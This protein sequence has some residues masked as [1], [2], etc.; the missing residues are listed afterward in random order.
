MT[1]WLG[2]DRLFGFMP[3]FVRSTTA[4]SSLRHTFPGLGKEFMPDLDE[5]SY[6]YMPTTM[7]HASIGEVLDILQ[8]Q[9][10][11]FAAIPE[12]ESVVGKL[13]RVDSPL[14]P[15]PI[16]MIETVINYKPEYVVDQNGHRLKFKYDRE[17][18]EF[19]KDENGELIPDDR[20]RPY[21]NWRDHIRNP[22]DI[23]DE[24]VKA[25]KLPGTTSAPR[26]QPIA[27][28]IVML[29]SGMRAPMGVKVKGPD[30]ETI[31]MVGMEIE[32]FL[33]EV[34]SI[35][36]A[37]VV[38]DRIVGKPYLEIDIDREAIARYGLS[39]Q[40]VQDV[41]E[42]A[43]GGKPLT[44]TVEG[45][46]RY[47]VR[48]RYQR[49]LRN[50]IEGLEGILVGSPGGVQIPL[51]ELSEIKFVRGPMVI[52][53]EDTFLVGYVIFDKKP[54]NAEVDVVR[55]AQ[56]YIQSK[57]EAGE[58]DIPAGVSYTFAGSY[59]NQVRSEKKLL[60]VLPL[61][62]VVIFLILYFQ[63]KHV[64]T[65]LL[66]FSGI[67]IAWSGGFLMIWLYGQDWFLDGSLFGIE[68]RS[69][70]QLRNYNLSVAVWV[71]FLA[72]FGIATDDGVIISTYLK[73]SFQRRKPTTIEGIREA[74]VEAG[75]RRIRPAMM[76]A[77][78]TLLA[79]I[80]V[81]TST[82]RGSDIMVPMAI[83]SFGGMFVVVIRVLTVPVLYSWMKERRLDPPGT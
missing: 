20:G 11:A 67:F 7:P 71:G 6:L 48:V 74:T 47:P 30:L 27:A 80:P 59:E 33:K 66:V 64:P 45:R 22:K 53:S 12:I 70:F 72:L 3:G 4:Y 58:F 17:F 46:E 41:I 5:G 39:I 37:A 24:I 42:V 36:P 31:E 1:V 79:L 38:A 77:A 9:D 15:A 69:L 81:L 73:Q 54:G 76:T 10:K 52:K 8:L 21:R 28:R 75:K 16:S 2:F 43:I 56:K 13:G 26:L 57:I 68:M 44:T 83:P 62:L 65:T 25:G 82:G 35:E 63:F 61:A 40:K 32:R 34:P 55:D 49:E 19:S 29:Q 50:T 60:V 51:T 18:G 23:W 78:T 14:D